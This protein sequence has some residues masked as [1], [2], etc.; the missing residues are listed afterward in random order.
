MKRLSNKILIVLGCILSGMVIYSCSKDFLSQPPYG[1]ASQ[2]D[3]NSKDGVNGLLI[4]AYSMLDGT[5]YDD[6]LV[7]TDQTTVWNP[8]AGSV[9]ADDGHKGGGYG[10]Q[11]ERQEL[12]GK[13]FTSNNTILEN[14]W[15]FGY[16]AV[17]RAN[18]TIRGL[19]RVNSGIFT[20]AEALQ[21]VAEARFLR[22]YYH[23]ELA[24]MFRN[25]PYVADTVTFAAG[26]YK[27]TNRPSGPGGPEGENWS[28]V[29]A[30]L[31]FAI[32][33]LPATQS[34]VGRVNSWA[35][36]AVLAKALMQQAKMTQALPILTDLINN[37]VTQKGVKYD[38]NPQF[39]QLWRAAFENDAEAVFAAQFS[40]ND[41]SRGKNGG[42]GETPNYPDRFG[43]W[44]HQPSF[45]LVNAFKTK[46]GYPMLDSFNVVD[47]KNNMGLALNGNTPDPLY[48][49]ETGTLD[50]RLDW[51]VARYA[52]PFHD[53][54]IHTENYNPSGGPYRGK[55]WVTWKADV[56]GG[57]GEATGNDPFSSRYNGNNFRII[58]F[59]DVLLL[60]AECEVEGGSLTKAQEYVNRVRTRAANPAGF[61]KTYNTPTDASSGFTNT[62]AANYK[63]ELYGAVPAYDFSVMGQAEARKA[64][65]FE[66]RIELAMEGHRFF[67]LQRYDLMD[68]GY[69]TVLMTQ[70][71]SSEVAKWEAYIPPFTYDILKGSV[72][73]MDKNEFY[74]IPQAQIDASNDGTGNTLIQNKGY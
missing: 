48:T 32:D 7:G 21:V 11:P 29:E 65:R 13:T 60:A 16:A 10:R 18:E 4:S 12:E 64:V 45:N 19:A 31:Q 25:I 38:L 74:A 17:Q 39:S 52:I 27:V 58:R 2:E 49:P 55:K 28:K 23:Y 22:G 47:V 26:N 66:R 37:G 61:L 51:T 70:Y 42:D 34:Q 69:M 20:D 30:D 33:N 35:A 54:F 24:K 72:F 46:D 5:G 9:A 56:G 67:D 14:R 3:L 1:S 41:G 50:P 53:W 36:K 57:L 73:T 59:A 63:V 71:I 62:P 40:V 43:G 68:H 8:W 6:W 15:K 44:G